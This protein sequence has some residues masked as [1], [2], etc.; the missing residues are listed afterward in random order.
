MQTG[1]ADTIIQARLAAHGLAC[2]RGD[3]VLFAGLSLELGAGDILHV[4][5]ANGVGKS[6]LLRLLGGLAR[7]FAGGVERCG[8]AGLLDERPVLDPAQALGRALGFWARVDG[9][10]A[11]ALDEACAAM[12]LSGLLDVP[13]RYLS[14]GQKKRAGLVRLIG[15]GAPVWLLDEPLNGLDG[16]AVERMIAVVGD[17]CRAGGLC[18]VAS[19]QPFELAGKRVLALEGFAA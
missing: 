3:R 9:C 19:H 18:V 17:H 11:A 2:R 15:Q 14:T 7:P 4:T 10:G 8:A 16:A 1:A 5:G 6:S 12:G 13:V